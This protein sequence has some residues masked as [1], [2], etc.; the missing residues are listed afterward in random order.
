MPRLPAR[1]GPPPPLTDEVRIEAARRY[2]EAFEQVTGRSFEP[3]LRP[4]AERIA[5]SIARVLA[6]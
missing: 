1:P 5:E 2:I 3:D 6:G 4:P